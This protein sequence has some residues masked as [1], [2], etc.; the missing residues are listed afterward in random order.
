MCDELQ[1][2][3]QAGRADQVHLALQQLLRRGRGR[4]Q[5]AWRRASK[6]ADQALSWLT[7]CLHSLGR[8]LLP[9]ISY[10][11]LSSKACTHMRC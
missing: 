7:R 1:V 10:R 9:H 5:R 3:G 8:W 4:A 2:A 6:A 11:P